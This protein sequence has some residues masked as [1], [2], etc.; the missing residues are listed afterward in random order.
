[1]S[2]TI[3]LVGAAG[4]GKGTVALRFLQNTFVCYPKHV[5]YPDDSLIT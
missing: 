1:M 5:L 4:V 3:V 2:R